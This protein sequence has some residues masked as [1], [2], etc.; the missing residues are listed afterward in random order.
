MISS[1]FGDNNEFESQYLSGGVEVELVPQ[2]T[3]KR[4]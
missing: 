1:Y 3:L 2:V 4:L